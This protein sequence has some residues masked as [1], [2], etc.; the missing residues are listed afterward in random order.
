MRV[1]SSGPVDGGIREDED[2]VWWGGCLL[3]EGRSV[4][5]VIYT[6]GSM[7]LTSGEGALE[8]NRRPGSQSPRLHSHRPT[9]FQ[10]SINRSPDTHLIGGGHRCLRRSR[11]AA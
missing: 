9:T 10:C 3:F 1:E 11:R 7:A 6:A 4:T 2:M 8:S 5:R